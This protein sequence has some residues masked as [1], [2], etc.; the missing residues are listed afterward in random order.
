MRLLLADVQLLLVDQ[1]VEDELGLDALDRLLLGLL[2]E[3]LLGLALDLQVLREVEAHLTELVV[4]QVVL[5]GV[6]LVR[7]QLLR[8]RHLGE[9]QQLFED[10]LLGLGGLV[11]LLHVLEALAAVRPGSSRV[12]NS[13]AVWAKSSSS[14]GSSRAETVRTL[15]VTSAGWP[16][17]APPFN[18]EVKVASPAGLQADDGLVDAVEQ[19]AG[20]DGVRHVAGHAVGQHLAVDLGLQVDRHDVA[21][22]GGALDHVGRREA[23]AELLD[24]LVDVLVGDL[25]GVHGDLDAGVVRDL[26]LG[27][28]VHLGGEGQQLAVLEAR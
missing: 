22:G 9:L 11:V 23:V 13:L 27:A 20:T 17:A 25:D 1:L 26:D 4:L 21:L 6:D 14:S 19:L 8:D 15:T 18:S 3:L 12:S 10:A 16:S 2:L 28:D 24:R 5:A 7:E